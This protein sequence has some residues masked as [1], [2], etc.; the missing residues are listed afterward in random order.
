MKKDLGIP[1]KILMMIIVANL[2]LGFLVFVGVPYFYLTNSDFSISTNDPSSET[3]KYN[4]YDEDSPD[5]TDDFSEDNTDIDELV[6]FK[7]ISGASAAIIIMIYS[8]VQSILVTLII[9]HVMIYET[10]R[11]GTLRTLSLYNV[12]MKD[13]LISKTINILI[14]TFIAGAFFQILFFILLLPLLALTVDFELMTLLKFLVC[15]LTVFFFISFLYISSVAIHSILMAANVRSKA[16]SPILYLFGIL[17]F[18]A[19]T[20]ETT[21]C[22]IFYLICKMRRDVYHRPWFADFML[23]SPLHSLGRAFDFILL[24]ELNGFHGAIWAWI[25]MGLIVIAFVVSKRIYPDILIKETA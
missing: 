18:S 23:L 10:E 11:F 8:A 3:S 22:G 17:S 20:S 25:L 2:V 14:M 9:L 19:L 1:F 5:N 21:L 15:Y 7:L 24:G 12:S 13:I 4:F 16:N 6:S